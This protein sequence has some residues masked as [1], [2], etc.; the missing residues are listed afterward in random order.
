MSTA[1]HRCTTT[2][3]YPTN[4]KECLARSV[5]YL[6][7]FA[8]FRV[9]RHRRPASSSYRE[10]KAL[11]LLVGFA[12]VSRT[13]FYFSHLFKFCLFLFKCVLVKYISKLAKSFIILGGYIHIGI[14]DKVESWGASRTTPVWHPD[15]VAG[16]S[17][18]KRGL[19]E[20]LP[21]ASSLYAT[22]LAFSSTRIE[23]RRY[24]DLNSSWWWGFYQQIFSLWALIHGNGGWFAV[25]LHYI[26]LFY[27]HS[28]AAFCFA[29][30]AHH[31]ST[32]AWTE[33][34]KGK[35]EDSL[36]DSPMHARL[37]IQ[38]FMWWRG[39]RKRGFN[40][41]AILSNVL[42]LFRLY[43]KYNFNVAIN[44]EKLL[45]FDPQHTCQH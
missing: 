14:Q 21:F 29:L 20:L 13:R 32:L 22:I 27:T 26:S 6:L 18:E 2:L 11:S 37:Y 41:M 33:G 12:Q 38:R 5:G 40:I 3:L 19:L 25:N 1:N 28:N 23:G 42:L 17:I 45:D 35:E 4:A 39:I 9:A 30:L 44:G 34:M 7:A 36:F 15:A 10:H 31:S 16:F 8:R 43:K 24:M